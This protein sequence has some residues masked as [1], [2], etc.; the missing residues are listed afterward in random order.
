MALFVERPG[1]GGGGNVDRA[2]APAADDGISYDFNAPPTPAAPAT[3]VLPPERLF[4]VSAAA[5]RGGGGSDRMLGEV[6]LPGWKAA[7]PRRQQEDTVV[8]DDD[9]DIEGNA[10]MKV[11]LTL[12]GGGCR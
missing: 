12:R 2:L 7:T 1:A 5:V 6:L 10:G 11:T 4:F 8:V 9:D 3:A